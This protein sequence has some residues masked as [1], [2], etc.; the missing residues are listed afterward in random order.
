MDLFERLWRDYVAVTPQAERIHALLAGRGETI[1]NDHIALRTFSRPRVGIEALARPFVQLGYRPG[2][3]YEFADKHLTARHYQHDDPDLPKVFISQLE[4]DRVPAIASIVD[5]LLETIDERVAAS[6]ELLSCGRP[7]SVDRATYDALAEHSEYAAW[8]AAFGYRANHFT[9]DVGRLHTVD[10]LPGLVELLV[11]EGFEL[12]PAGGL[13]KGSP[14]VY[15]E[16]ASTRADEVPVELAGGTHRLPSC[17]YEFARRYPMPDGTV[18][19]G[20]VTGSADRL[21]ESTDRRRD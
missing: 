19:Q 9:V 14:A 18:F 16:Q 17:Y 6:P 2:G 10:G 3:D 12:N 1:V 20:F 13:I 21:F 4:L 11:A 15:L 7:W 8:V 5:C